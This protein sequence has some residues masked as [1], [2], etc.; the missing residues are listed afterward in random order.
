[1]VITIRYYAAACAA[2]GVESETREVPDG[3]TLA[4]VLD[5]LRNGGATPAQGPGTPTLAD[6]L[7][8]CSYLVNEVAAKDLNRRL[9]EGDL[10]D[11]LPPFA[12]G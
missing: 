1:M 9:A 5:L 6:V 7:R 8:R 12:G 2:A 11:V 4:G 3:A 10:L